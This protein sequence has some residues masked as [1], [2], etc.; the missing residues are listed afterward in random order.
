VITEQG[1]GKRSAMSEY[2][3]QGRAGQGV[4]GM[5]VTPGDA[6]VGVSIAGLKD[7]LIIT[8]S[9]G[10]TK[11]VK[12]RLFKSLGRATGG[13]GVQHVVKNEVVTAL[14]KPMERI[15]RAEMTAA[16]EQLQLPVAGSGKKAK[17]AKARPTKPKP[18]RKAPAKVRMKAKAR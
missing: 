16:P 13:Y 5:R 11:Q 14:V 1:L 10:K 17:P 15:S 8:T 12:V 3:K 7:N 6:V 9:R 4:I 18:G 2:P